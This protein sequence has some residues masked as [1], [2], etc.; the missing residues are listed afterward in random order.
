M[1]QIP[2]ALPNASLDV[3]CEDAA[4]YNQAHELEGC[5]KVT[6]HLLRVSTRMKQEGT[7]RLQWKDV[8]GT[9]HR[10]E[11]EAH[12]D[13]L[14]QIPYKVRDLLKETGLKYDIT[15]EPETPSVLVSTGFKRSKAFYGRL[16][17]NLKGYG[18]PSQP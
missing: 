2:P 11:K 14:D 15:P 16:I 17:E 6:I 5:V 18:I 1:S 10:P 8:F 4:L 9:I 13:Y 7:V 3:R 12:F